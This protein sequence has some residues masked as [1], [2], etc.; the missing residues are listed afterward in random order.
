MI[1][2]EIWK[3]SYFKR[4]VLR[5]QKDCLKQSVSECVKLK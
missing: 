3:L 5:K 1:G 4:A 2:E